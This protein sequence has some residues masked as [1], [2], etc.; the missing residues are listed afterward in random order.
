[1]PDAVDAREI[2]VYVGATSIRLRLR[3]AGCRAN[4]ARKKTDK[5]VLGQRV[6]EGGEGSGIA[7]GI[8]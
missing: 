6:A 5:F 1:V 4:Q 2:S 7:V 3:Y 8:P